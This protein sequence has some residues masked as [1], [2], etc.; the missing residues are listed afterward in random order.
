MHATLTNPRSDRVRRVRH[1]LTTTGRRRARAFLVEGPQG[2]REA[3]RWAPERV[4]DVY[5]TIEAS[6][7]HPEIVDASADSGLYMHLCSPDVVE[8]MSGD[9][10]GVVAVVDSQQEARA[11]FTRTG[12]GG[13]RFF[14]G[15]V[16]ARDPG[17]VG[18]IIRAADAAGAAGVVLTKGSV[19]VENP[20]VVRSTAGSMFHVPIAWGLE[21]DALI[22]SAV[23]SGL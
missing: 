7:R 18:A 10:Q 2:V 5:L 16:H 3:T 11:D 6:Q 20:K 9:A 23:N 12:A 4:R 21:P 22:D 17:N 19:S 13:G 8:A 15:L 1:L 14:V